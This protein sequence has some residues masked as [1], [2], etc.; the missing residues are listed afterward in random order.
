MLTFSLHSP[1]SAAQGAAW[2]REHAWLLKADLS[3]LLLSCPQAPRPHQVNLGLNADR[4]TP[5]LLTVQRLLLGSGKVAAETWLRWHAMCSNGY[6]Q[7]KY[8]IHITMGS[9]FI[10]NYTNRPTQ[11]YNIYDPPNEIWT[12]LWAVVFIALSVLLQRIF[13][14]LA[15]AATSSLHRF[16]SKIKLSYQYIIREVHVTWRVTTDGILVP[17][18]LDELLTFFWHVVIHRPMPTHAVGIQ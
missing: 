10:R 6:T 4:L 7:I 3:I 12:R 15:I 8:W 11:K 13:F 16:A 5:S 17:Y 1:A 2:E 14:M 9:V 18:V